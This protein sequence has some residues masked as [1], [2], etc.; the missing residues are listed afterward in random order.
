M[1]SQSQTSFIPKKPII[2]TGYSY[3]NR[4]VSVVTIIC[5]VV[6]FGAVALSAGSYLYKN[7]LMKSLESKKEAL[8]KARKG[9]DLDTVRDL[10][11]LGSRI[12]E[13]GKLLNQHIAT[14]ALFDILEDA[15][16]KYV[17][18]LDMS[19]FL[20]ENDGQGGAVEG[21]E[22]PSIVSGVQF[23]AKG[24]ARNYTSVAL[25]SDVFNRTKGF[26]EPIISDLSLDTNGNINFSVSAIIDPQL[27]RFRS[28]IDSEGL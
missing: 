20:P 9:F 1:D 8:E 11:R 26:R 27:L 23:K 15:T 2:Q 5:I 24:N 19:L 22:L 14:S 10:K 3:E 12:E 16:I 21:S 7:F 17:R 13:S 18:F 28:V 6:F 25:Q 4:G